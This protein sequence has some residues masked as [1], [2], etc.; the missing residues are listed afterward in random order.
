MA[1]VALV[2]FCG[3]ALSA[4]AD[5]TQTMRQALLGEAKH[6]LSD[7]FLNEAWTGKPP[8]GRIDFPH[9]EDGIQLQIT[10]GNYLCDA[11]E[12]FQP[13]EKIQLDPEEQPS[14]PEAIPITFGRF[15]VGDADPIDVFNVLADT[16]AQE[17]WDDLIHGGPGVTLLGDFPDEY[18]RGV[19]MTFVA[20]PFPDRQVFQWE[21]YNSSQNHDDMWVVF[22][23]RRN[24]EL[25]KLKESEA[26][27]A[28]QAQNC[29]GAYHVV[30]LP[31]GGC[32]IVFTTQV[33]SHPPW[34]ITAK[35]VFNMLWTKTVGYIQ[36]VRKRS[37]MLKKQR[38]AAHSQAVVPAVPDWLLYDGMKPDKTASGKLWVENAPKTSP[39]FGGPDYVADIIQTDSVLSHPVLVAN[40]MHLP[41]LWVAASFSLVLGLVATW[42]RLRRGAAVD[43]MA[44]DTVAQQEDGTAPPLLPE[45]A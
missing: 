33:N 13:F 8:N 2:L 6:R 3:A 10:T 12:R 26:W 36:Q 15:D 28:V 38:L 21:A 30:A 43:A 16:K 34:P 1:G 14:S 42:K 40:R 41:I 18:A 19:A 44:F 45:E 23:T 24:E 20:H 11:E 27:P 22:S 39:P 25:H 9:E 29:L 35:F 7:W 17:E 37:Q 31:Q 5:T 32:H 4:A